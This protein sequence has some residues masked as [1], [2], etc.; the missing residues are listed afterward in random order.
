MYLGESNLVN[1]FSIN[2]CYPKRIRQ[3]KPPLIKKT[4]YIHLALI[5]IQKNT[6]Y[7]F[8]YLVFFIFFLHLPS[9]GKSLQELIAIAISNHP[10]IK[11]AVAQRDAA[12]QTRKSAG[13]QFYPTP[14]LALQTA[15]SSGNNPNFQG[16]AMVFTLG[17]EQPIWQG[18]KRFSDVDQ[19]DIDIDISALKIIKKQYQI[20]FDLIDAYGK[21]LSA[22]NKLSAFEKSLKEHE[23]LLHRV[24]NR[25]VAGVSNRGDIDLALTRFES[26]KA[27]NISAQ[28]KE[29]SALSTIIE[30][31]NETI[32][33]EDMIQSIAEPIR[34]E[35]DFKIL[36]ERSLSTHPNILIARKEANK[37]QK[38]ISSS[39]ASLW[40]DIY[41][42]VEQQVG[43]FSIKG[44]PPSTTVLIGVKS[45]LGAGLSS[46]S[47]IKIST[48]EL[49][50]AEMDVETQK[51]QLKQKTVE[52]H[53]M[54]NS[55]RAQI[56]AASATLE[57]AEKVF[58]SYSR[59]FLAG[60]KSWLDLMNSLREMT[61]D[62]AELA[63][64]SGT[65][66][67]TS[68]RRDIN[69]NGLA[70][71]LGENQTS[72]QQQPSEKSRS[73]HNKQDKISE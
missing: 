18:G 72:N 57:A 70:A 62:K 65:L 23:R 47:D 42:K 2:E 26:T 56:K 1:Y 19:A 8:K 52:A 69:I 14:S 24:E 6:Q 41:L 40:P 34:Q 5:E 73:S 37:S 9:H 39:K 13:W 46:F 31:V 50:S 68:I 51:R 54:E 17:I 48:A 55:L 10:A 35:E 28:F 20:A 67:S 30:I 36:L 3:H 7:F 64:L 22:Y 11:S 12:R 61:S 58:D 49:R 60:R 4:K 32:T 59:Q 71:Y 53:I 16:D 33:A 43:N 15:A 63:D 66:L 25:V 38:K 44:A 21:W 27:Q 45:Q 29:S